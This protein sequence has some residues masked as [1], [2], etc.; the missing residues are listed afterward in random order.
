MKNGLALLTVGIEQILLPLLKV[1][2]EIR[3]AKCE[4][5]L[6]DPFYAKIEIIVK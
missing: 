6:C 1:I 4:T 2:S 5:T 3:N